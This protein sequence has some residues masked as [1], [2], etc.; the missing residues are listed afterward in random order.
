MSDAVD[1]GGWL[2]R[3]RLGATATVPWWAAGR[4]GGSSLRPLRDCLLGVGWLLIEGGIPRHM[5]LHLTE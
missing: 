4:R 1:A 3:C 5:P 2:R